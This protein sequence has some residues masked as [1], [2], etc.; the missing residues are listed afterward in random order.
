MLNQMKCVFLYACV[1]RLTLL[2]GG[3]SAV[4][5]A[6]ASASPCAP[7]VGFVDIPHP[8]IAAREKFVSRTEEI[9]I[10][11]TLIAV[12]RAV[13]KPLIDTISHTGSLPGV[14]GD[15]ML[16]EGEFGT[17]GSR[18]LTC[19]SDGSTLEE[20]VLERGQT[21]DTFHFRYVVWNYTSDK[22]RPIDFAVGDFR[23]AEVSRGRTHVEWT[24]SFRLK[25]QRFPGQLGP[26]GRY[27]FQVAF[28]NRDYAAMMRS[29]LA[30]YK[31][32]A[33]SLPAGG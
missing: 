17:P 16:T 20:E 29:V 13:N 6:P 2:I 31:A 26:L 8:E 22:A 24:Y 5:S 19:L 9:T 3:C 12:L 7:P 28:L 18:R 15:Y 11:R 4:F 14:S 1:C 27:L 25:T 30:G 10:E 23:Y 33:E 32:D 21:S